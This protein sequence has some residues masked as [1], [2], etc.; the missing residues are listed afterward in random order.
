LIQNINKK[1][2]IVIALTTV[3]TVTGEIS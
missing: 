1:S 3:S 2:V